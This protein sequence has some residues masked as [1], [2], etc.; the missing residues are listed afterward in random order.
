[1]HELQ[2]ESNAGR[3]LPRK[4]RREQAVKQEAIYNNTG[5]VVRLYFVGLSLVERWLGAGSGVNP[6]PNLLTVNR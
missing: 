6:N 1:M 5:A 4:E 2:S 3:T